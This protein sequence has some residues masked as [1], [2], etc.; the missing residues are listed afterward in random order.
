MVEGALPD[1][2]TEVTA[3]ADS[4]PDENAAEN[5]AFE[6]RLLRIKA[7]TLSFHNVIDLNDE[8]SCYVTITTYDE[9]SH[10]TLMEAV[11]SMP[12]E[13]TIKRYV[14]SLDDPLFVLQRKTVVKF[15]NITDMEDA[16]D[17]VCSRLLPVIHLQDANLVVGIN[18]YRSDGHAFDLHYAPTSRSDAVAAGGREYKLTST[19]RS[20]VAPANYRP[21]RKIFEMKDDSFK[22]ISETITGQVDGFVAEV[23]GGLSNIAR[24]AGTPTIKKQSVL[25]H[26]ASNLITALGLSLYLNEIGIENDTEVVMTRVALHDVIEIKTGDILRPAKDDFGDASKR[27]RKALRDVEN[28]AY[29]KLFGQLKDTVHYHRYMEWVSDGDGNEVEADIAKLAD[30]IDVVRYADSEVKIG[31]SNFVEIGKKAR[32]RMN[33]KIRMILNKAESER[34]ALVAG[35]TKPARIRTGRE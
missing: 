15:S 20:E 23:V 32:E 31:N 10:A 8:G 33:D 5:A 13:Y 11:L 1:E 30:I 6:E 24:Y 19:E 21:H 17:L 12:L 22:E 25:E 29:R 2:G 4:D 34:E 28:V 35:S 16:M 9:E 7:A 14:P 26:T 27:L 18:F 3:R